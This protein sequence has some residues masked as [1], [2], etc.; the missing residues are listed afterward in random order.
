MPK[1]RWPDAKKD[2]SPVCPRRK[3]GAGQVGKS[4]PLLFLSLKVI[5]PESGGGLHFKK[6]YAKLKF[7]NLVEDSVKT[8]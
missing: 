7:R 4:P 2:I 8:V 5:L 6:V 1:P 3:G